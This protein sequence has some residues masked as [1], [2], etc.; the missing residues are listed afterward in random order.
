M[1]KK[2][3]YLGLFLIAVCAVS[4]LI[5]FSRM[6]SE[7]FDDQQQTA[8]ATATETTQPA[9]PEPLPTTP[10]TTNADFIAAVNKALSAPANQATDK[11]VIQ[12]LQTRISGLSSQNART[13]LGEMGNP[14]NLQNPRTF[15]QYMNWFS[16]NCP[17]ESD[18]CYGAK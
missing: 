3:V 9:E 10:I 18:T 4:I 16:S 11:A 5:P 6:K 15:L 7:G 14:N 17:I 12:N 1:K 8:D 13:I 2:I